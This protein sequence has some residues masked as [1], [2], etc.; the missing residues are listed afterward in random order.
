MRG[1]IGGVGSGVT[2]MNGQRRLVSGGFRRRA[3]LGASGGTAKPGL[4]K[5]TMHTMNPPLTCPGSLPRTEQL[6]PRPITRLRGWFSSWLALLAVVLL[7]ANHVTAAP[8]IGAQ[9]FAT[10]GDIVVE[11]QPATAGFV[12]ELWLYS[13]GPAQFI[14]LNTDV[15]LSVN[16]GSFPAG[17]E[18]IFGIYVRN[19]GFTYQMGPGSRNPDGIPHAAVDIVNPG[20]AL[21]G[22]EDLFGGGDLDYDDNVF[23]FIGGIAP[24][25]CPADIT[26]GTSPGS[27][28]AV[29]NYTEPVVDGATVVCEPPSGSEFPLGTTT[30]TCVATYVT[31]ETRECSFTVTVVDREGPEIQCPLNVIAGNDPGRCSAVVEFVATAADSCSAVTVVSVPPSGS[32]FPVGTTVVTTTATDAAGNPTTCTFTV[33]VEDREAP[34]VE[35]VPTTNPSGQNV[36]GANSSPA[37]GRNPDGFYELLASDNCDG[38][39]LAIYVKDSAEGPCGGAF[40]AG[41]YAPGTKVKLTQSPGRQ[42]EKP[43]AGVIA[44]HIHT[45]GEPVLVVVDS[46]GNQ[47]CH[48]CFVPPPPK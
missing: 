2:G 7:P 39:D 23:R 10:G 44:A 17:S 26:V 5:Q 41:P 14:A 37:S 48:E 38:A 1:F 36:P 33:T 40:A 29:V 46:S 27:C 42:R 18:L 15:G 11:V 43:M 6:L 13:P 30:V 34:V 8:I 47:T 20:D 19:T 21:V 31:G 9:L 28:S 22:F 4:R 32:E 12:S 25:A 3:G 35:C 24:L 45:R 16:I